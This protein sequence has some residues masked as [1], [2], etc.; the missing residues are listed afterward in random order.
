MPAH[1]N[2]RWWFRV[3]ALLSPICLLVLVEVG[4]DL[5]GY[6][7]PTSFFLE[8]WH[9]GRTLLVENPKFGWRFFPPTL[10][11]TPSPCPWMR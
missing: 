7:Y 2:K 1:T 6:G 3:L 4:L 8:K 10:A 9:D 5:A 11:R